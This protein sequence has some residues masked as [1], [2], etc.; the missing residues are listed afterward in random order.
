MLLYLVPFAAVA[1][2]LVAVVARL[3][4]IYSLPVHLRWELY[5][6][7][8]EQNAAYGGSFFEH[9][10]WWQQPRA[11]RHVGEL[12]VMVPEI[13]FLVG[14]R[15]HNRPLWARTFPFHFG[16]YLSAGLIALLLLGGVLQA[17]GVT[18][19]GSAGFPGAAVHWLTVV[20][21]Y[22]GTGLCL[23]G[24]LALL[25]RRLSDPV[26]RTHSAP[27]DLWNL[28]A[29]VATGGLAL[30]A[31]LVCDRDLALLR[32]FTQRVVTFRLGGEVP[33]LLAIAIVAASAMVAYVPTTHMA[34]F[35]TKWF[36]YHDV[37]WNDEVNTV[38]SKLEKK[39]QA[40]LA[41]K[42]DWAAPHI[43][44]GGTKTWVDV[45]TEEVAKR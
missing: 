13:L 42:V 5:P 45:A 21:A 17:A 26:L 9:V 2:F 44:G 15:E 23:I 3:V 19:A 22:A 7:A 4:R 34:H 6:V 31:F 1:I 36:M 40:Q 27:A 43:Q 24:A 38:G 41:Y 37:R 30:L 16:L 12:K 20:F 33:T 39:I 14:V 11:K 8:H 28:V 10:D 18:V 32:G 35:F 25:L 29:F